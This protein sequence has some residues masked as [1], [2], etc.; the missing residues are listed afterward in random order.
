MHGNILQKRD[1]TFKKGLIHVIAVQWGKSIRTGK[2]IPSTSVSCLNEAA[3]MGFFESIFFIKVEDM[4]KR[5]LLC[6]G[7]V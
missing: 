3:N 5:Q 1:Q 6:G 2:K 7:T 4:V